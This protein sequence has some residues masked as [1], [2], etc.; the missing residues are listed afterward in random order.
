MIQIRNS[1]EKMRIELSRDRHDLRND[2]A[3]IVASFEVRIKDVEKDGA[4]KEDLIAVESRMNAT[5]AEMKTEMR[6]LNQKADVTGNA[7]AR[8]MEK[9]GIEKHGAD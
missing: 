3:K 8:I 7:L 5:F 9:M 6:Q 2:M 4:R 1:E